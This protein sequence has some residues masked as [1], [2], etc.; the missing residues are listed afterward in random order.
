MTKKIVKKEQSEKKIAKFLDSA[1]DILEKAEK[2]IAK[3][4]EGPKKF[5]GDIINFFKRHKKLLI[6]AGILYL[7]FEF[8]FGEP[9]VKKED[10][11][12]DGE[13]EESSGGTKM[14]W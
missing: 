12:E 10:E 11:E 7:L 5:I 14:M 1:N 8:L 6:T 9:K 4:S 13:D 3:Y 2:Q